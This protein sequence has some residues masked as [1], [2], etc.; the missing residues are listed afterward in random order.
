MPNLFSREPLNTGRQPALDLARG[1]AVLFMIFIH[2]LL[3][4]A[5]GE[6]RQSGFGE[7]VD[8]AGGVPAAPV[9]MV[10]LG[11]GLVYSRINTPALLVRRGL[12]LLLAGYALNCGRALLPY[13]LR[14]ALGGGPWYLDQALGELVF[15]DILQFAGLALIFFGLLAR[16]RAG[17]LAVGL[18]A[19][20]LAGL[21]YALLPVQPEHPVLR[22]LA[23]L[24]WG[25]DDRSYFPFLTWIFYPLAGYLYGLLLV[26]TPDAGAFHRRAFWTGA[27]ALLL[28]A[29]VLPALTGLHPAPGSETEYYHHTLATNL[30]FTA[31]V[32]AW[33]ALLHFAAGLV[34]AFAKGTIDRWSRNVTAIYVIHWLLI[35]AVMLFLPF[36]SLD[37]PAFIALS[38]GIAA[39]SDGL[40]HLWTRRRRKPATRPVPPK[41]GPGP[42]G[43][44][45]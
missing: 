35:G 44:P 20:G 9:F 29:Q 37:L 11:I 26:R 32:A 16:F 38:L 8:F 6:A 45:G 33:I 12:G 23:G 21:N 22:A 3:Y 30:T 15:V 2:V 25:A 42:A 39:A 1:L 19:L 14:W 41:A 7:A 13:G 5:G 27:A 28:L 36:G 31:F 34:P 10:L 4:T 18:L 40:A 43:Q 17:P 24:V